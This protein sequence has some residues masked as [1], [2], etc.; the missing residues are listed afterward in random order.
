MNESMTPAR[1]PPVIEMI[2]AENISL[3][4]DGISNNYVLQLYKI[5]LFWI[6][7]VYNHMTVN[8]CQGMKGITSPHSG[9]RSYTYQSITQVIAGRFVPEGKKINNFLII[10]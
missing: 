6:G 2:S 3:K 5:L 9:N 8:F 4:S 10:T 7:F 1:S